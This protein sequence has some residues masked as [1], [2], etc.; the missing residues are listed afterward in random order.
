[1]YPNAIT[2]SVTT[3]ANG[4][5]TVYTPSIDGRL[6]TII[7]TK[8]TFDNG[9][10][11]TITGEQSGQTLWDEDNVNASKI[12]APRQ[13]THTTAGVAITYDS[14]RNVYDKIVLAGERIKIVIAQGGASKSGKFTFIFD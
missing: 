4:D 9:V 2:V 7:Y 6:S 11:F 13:Q 1:M 5:A 14:T 3:D 10:D 12:I 8:D